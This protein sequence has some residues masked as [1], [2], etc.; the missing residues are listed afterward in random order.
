MDRSGFL[1][2]KGDFGYSLDV[3]GE[4]LGGIW[5]KVFGLSRGESGAI[6]MGIWAGLG[7]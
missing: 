4:V 2:V 5:H 1:N 3:V 7:M 6:D